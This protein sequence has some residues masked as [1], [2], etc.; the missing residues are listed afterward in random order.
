MSNA[1]VNVTELAG[2]IQVIV[3][4]ASAGGAYAAQAKAYAELAFAYKNAAL[5]AQQAA[6]AYATQAAAQAG[7]AESAAELASAA[8]QASE[9]ASQLADAARV[10]AGVARDAAQAAATVAAEDAGLAHEYAQDA[11]ASKNAAAL[12]AAAAATSARSAAEAA[13]SATAAKVSAENAKADAEAA[14]LLASAAK[15]DATAA[16][17]DAEQF[18]QEAMDNAEKAF[19]AL[20]TETVSA[21]IASI[22]D[23]AD[24]IPVKSLVLDI[25]PQQAGSGDPSPDNVRPIS[26]WTGATIFHSGADT[27]DPMILRMSWESEAGSVYGGTLDVT[28]GLLTITHVKTTP[29]GGTWSNASVFSI[30]T[31]NSTW[32]PAPM[33]SGSWQNDAKTMANCL[34]KGARDASGQKPTI[35]FGANTNYIYI[36]NQTLLDGVTD[37]A[38][39]IAWMAD[40]LEITYPLATPITYQLTPTE[41]TTL[42]G[43]NNIWADTGDSAVTY[44][45]DVGMYV[46]KRI[47]ALMAALG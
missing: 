13:T 33:L 35:L 2:E 5:A 29:T 24:G 44:R 15:T 39:M 19:A 22:Y 32:M 42:L 34:E 37:Y 47:A 16:A 23:G 46:D 18:A 12:S 10:A 40:N 45:A 14:A 3:D 1:N 43:V 17:Q 25:V 27:S 6:E 11:E 41:V 20:P 8:A 21:P 38:T 30:N 28:T 9:S 31:A 4:D 7:D 26:G 36:Y